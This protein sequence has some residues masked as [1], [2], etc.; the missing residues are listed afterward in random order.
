MEKCP[1]TELSAEEFKDFGGGFSYKINYDGNEIY[2]TLGHAFEIFSKSEFFIDNKHILAGGILTNQLL[3]GNSGKLKF[4]SLSESDWKDKI[5][6]VDYPKSPKDKMDNLLK[7]LYQM[8]NYDGEE[9]EISELAQKSAFWYKHFFKNQY[10]CYFYFGILKSQ[11]LIEMIDTS[12]YG[13]PLQYN[14]TLHGLNY[15]LEITESGRLSNKCFVAMSFSEETKEIREAIR[16]ALDK[17]NFE[18]IIIDETHINS[19]QT[20][21]DKI[22]ADLK[23]AKFCIAD[24][25]E[26]KRGVYFESGFAVGQGKPVIYCCRNDHWIDTHFDTKHFAHILYDTP[27]ELKEGL[28]NKINAW[29]K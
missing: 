16:S 7:T 20:I 5:E 11:N 6:R 4:F 9:I 17:T 15:F 12:N 24:F 28:I 1:I 14:F 13:L 23:G 18:P 22:I 3:D 27:S 8:Q 2:I 19:D 10:E 21:N 29:I 26:Q 25:T